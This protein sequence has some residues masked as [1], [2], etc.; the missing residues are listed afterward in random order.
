MG[1]RVVDPAGN[2]LT[3]DTSNN[4][5]TGIGDSGDTITV[6]RA[7]N[8]A[9]LAGSPTI[10]QANSTSASNPANIAGN[11]GTLTLGADGSYTYAVDNTNASV[12][13]LKVGASLVD[14]FTYQITDKN[15]LT[16]IATLTVTVQGANDA[17][18]ASDTSI[19]TGINTAKTGSLPAATDPES[20]TVSY[21]VGS[22]PSHGSLSIGTNGSYIYT[23][24]TG[25]TGLDSFTYT[26]SDGQGG[27]ATYTVSVTVGNTPATFG[28]A[29]TGNVTEDSGSYTVGGTLTVTDPDSATTVVGADERGGHLRHVQHRHGGRLEL[30]GGQREAATAEHDGA[31]DGDVARC[32]RRTARRTPS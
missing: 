21:A 11:Y 27:S 15:G 16:A 10:V 20:D 29:D 6:T 17:P 9:S 7:S 14:T 26:V 4:S 19:T 31:G 18:T 30:R 5:G 8:G 28:G 1:R 2:V 32:T 22:N 3:G 24:T 23:P 13:A 25:Y 12:N